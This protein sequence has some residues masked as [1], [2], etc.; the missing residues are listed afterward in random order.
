MKAAQIRDYGHIEN[1]E[2]VEI[3]KPEPGRGQVLVEVHAA[4]LNPF[5]TAVREGH[6]RQMADIPLP[7]TLGGDFAGV[8]R[9][10]GAGV[11]GYKAGDRVYGQ[12][13]A[14]AGGSGAFAEYAVTAAGQLAPAPAN[15]GFN[16][17]ASLVLVGLSALQA[18]TEHMELK[19]GQKLFVHGGSGGIGTVAI[20]IAKELG[21][22][23]AA[24]A[25]GDRG[26]FVKS[27]GADEVIDTTK[28]DYSEMLSGYDAILVL[29]RGEEW[30]KL[31]SVLRPKGIAVS[32][33][34]PVDE[35]AARASDVTV[36]AQGTGTSPARLD[37]LRGFIERDVVTPQ[38]ARVYP[39][40]EIRE[41]FAHR[42]GGGVNGKIVIE[43][44]A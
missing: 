20:Q 35:V 14:L 28:Q 38:V 19:K 7:A 13:Q 40:S 30:D 33:V 11:V 41:A 16:E 8:V 36:F 29:V 15:L 37:A 21:A 4:S 12:A 24:S 5:D 39:L 22:Y 44:K 18:L 23:V 31:L 32:L 26:D 10:A 3:D 1:V 34:G 9:A 2:V 25:K 6:A 42:E 43:V 27:L 17:A